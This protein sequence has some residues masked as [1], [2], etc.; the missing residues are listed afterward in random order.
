MLLDGCA[1]GVDG[2]A[3]ARLVELAAQFEIAPGPRGRHRDQALV[4]EG[5][6][7]AHRRGVRTERPLGAGAP[8]AKQF[9]ARVPARRAG[10]PVASPGT[11]IEESQVELVRLRALADG[12]GRKEGGAQLGAREDLRGIRRTVDAGRRRLPSSRPRSR[13]HPAARTH[14]PR[15]P[16]IRRP[17]SAVP[18]HSPLPAPAPVPPPARPPVRPQPYSTQDVGLPSEPGTR[19]MLMLAV[20]AGESGAIPELS[21]NGVRMHAYASPR[22]CRQ[23]ARAVRPGMTTSGSRGVGR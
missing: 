5:V 4:D 11:L 9:P 17:A 1:V 16:R 3:G 19:C 7:V 21:R 20:A 12:L 15:R 22:T 13:P 6:V 8:H 23:P 10:A 18:R 14:C 2:D